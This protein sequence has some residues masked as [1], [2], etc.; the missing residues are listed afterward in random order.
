[1]ENVLNE[2]S[3]WSMDLPYWEQSALEKIIDGINFTEE[4]YEKLLQYMLEDNGLSEVS[5]ERP[6]LQF[7]LRSEIHERTK[8][9]HLV[10]K[11]IANLKNV[12][13]LAS[14]QEIPFGDNLTV[15]YGENGSGKSG[16]AR[17]L[18]C[19]GFTRGDKE[20]FP[21]I[22]EKYDENKQPTA[23]IV[24]S[25]GS[26]TQ[27]IG[28]QYGKQ[29]IVLNS[30]YVFDSTSVIKH[31]TEEN[32][33]SFTPSSLSYLTKL[34]DITDIVRSRLENI[35]Q[36][37][38]LQNNFT[39]LFS[40]ESTIKDF[41]STINYKTDLKRLHNLSSISE[42]DQKEMDHLEK[43]IV[44]LKALDVQ[45]KIKDLN[46]EK[47]DLNELIRLIST[48]ENKLTEN[49]ITEIGNKILLFNK[50]NSIIYSNLL[51]YKEDTSS[52]N[53]FDVW[54][55]FLESAKQYADSNEKINKEY[56]KK[57]D[58]CLLCNQLLSD[59]ANELLKNIW[60]LLKN[61]TK[62]KCEEV[63]LNLINFQND[64]EKINC[65]FFD[66][67]SKYYRIIEKYDLSLIQ[68]IN[69]ML[70]DYESLRKLVIDAIEYKKTIKYKFVEN[71]VI[72]KI[73]KIINQINNDITE[74]QDHHSEKK[75]PDLEKRFREYSHK[76]ILQSNLNLIEKHINNLIW[77]SN[78]EK[79]KGN[80]N[81]ITKMYNQ[82]F[83]KLVTN[84]YID[85]FK[86]ILIELN[87]PLKVIISTRGSKGKQLKQILFES[88]SSIPNK[89][90]NPSKI[91]SEGE[92][93]AVSIADFLTEV[94]L[95]SESDGIILDDPVT[96]LDIEWKDTISKILIKEAK[97]RQV[98]IFTHDLTFLYRLVTDA[99]ENDVQII[100]HWIKKGLNNIPGYIFPNN[101]PSLEQ[102]YRKP[103]KAEEL[104]KQ[105]LTESPEIQENTLRTGFGALRTTYEAFIIFEL[106]NGV[107]E[108]FEE[109]ISFGRLKDII[110]D[111]SIVKEVIKKCE[112]LSR[113]IEGH[114]HSDIYAD[115]KPTPE[116]LK[117][118]IEEF[119][120]IKKKLKDLQK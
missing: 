57:G 12:N 90:K 75:I 106:F 77:A 36:S 104:Y 98:I 80:T 58:R 39:H 91:L 111:N 78:A 76:K 101:C 9:G 115:K 37:K 97:K 112:I 42:N 2:I 96:S 44:Q 105:S 83:K 56:P 67:Q 29:A 30:F 34:S 22:N 107:V 32:A 4:D 60:N 49:S 53:N 48:I 17:V 92:K 52:S 20:I 64:I 6:K 15:I 84:K 85:I 61:E 8:K 88:E 99:E 16:Y 117:N 24:L 50:L 45:K 46:L 66:N 63:K 43:E 13:A 55:R 102:Q 23:E 108:R 31:L 113:Y 79:K 10:L 93:R 82:L 100:N 33:Y 114:S 11:K 47:T 38:K 94:R 62:I 1:M 41:I 118:E 51:L 54:F 21:N 86:E 65:K 40:E 72:D 95:D 73:T 3:H 7:S 103:E 35:I 87:R 69:K 110:W 74:M 19:A 28:Y 109:R 27:T 120:R 25:D 89:L 119:K 5:N 14:D 18:G 59:E 70:L 71:S 81:H 68:V 116:L 26:S